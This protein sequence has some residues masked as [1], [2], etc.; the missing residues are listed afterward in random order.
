MRTEFNAQSDFRIVV[1]DAAGEWVDYRSVA[2]LAL[3]CNGKIKGLIAVSGYGLA[4]GL[5]EPEKV[6]EVE[7]FEPL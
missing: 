2:T 4:G 3:E 7:P 1:G 6:Y 5:L